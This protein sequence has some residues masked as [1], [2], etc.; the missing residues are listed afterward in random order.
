MHNMN[1]NYINRLAENQ[2]IQVIRVGWTE[3]DRDL[4]LRYGLDSTSPSEDAIAKTKF[5]EPSPFIP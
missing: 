2:S 4:E 5:A 1:Q 3:Q